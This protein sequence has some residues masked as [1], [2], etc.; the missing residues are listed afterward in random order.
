M[1]ETE[2][3]IL[4]HYTAMGHSVDLIGAVI[5]GTQMADESA[6]EKNDCVSRNVE[7]LELMLTRDYW[8]SEDMTAVDAAIVAGKAYNA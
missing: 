2:A 1:V 4:Q 6:D 8:T 5:D 7:H 3:G